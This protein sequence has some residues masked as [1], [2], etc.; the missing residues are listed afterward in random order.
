[1]LGQLSL[2]KLY[3][4]IQDFFTLHLTEFLSENLKCGSCFHLTISAH[5]MDFISLLKGTPRK[6]KC[7]WGILRDDFKTQTPVDRRFRSFLA[8]F[9]CSKQWQPLG[10]G[11][12]RQSAGGW[13]LKSLIMKGCTL[14]L[15]LSP[16]YVRTDFTTTQTWIWCI[17]VNWFLFYF[18]S[19]CWRIKV[20]VS[21]KTNLYLD[22]FVVNIKH[23][24]VKALYREMTM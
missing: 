15:G 10:T 21:N 14:I 7:S 1:M 6:V 9:Y 20:F 5:V 23:W 18:I 22:Q 17:K 13:V 11:R 24:S 3:T 2:K 4:S 8:G 16:Y 12:N 19:L